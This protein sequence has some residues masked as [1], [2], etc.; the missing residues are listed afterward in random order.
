MA[1]SDPSSPI[2]I[3]TLDSTRPNF[4]GAEISS[5]FERFPADTANQVSWTAKEV[6]PAE[7]WV[8]FASGSIFLH[9]YTQ[10]TDPNRPYVRELRDDVS[11][12]GEEFIYQNGYQLS[13]GENSG[14]YHMLFP[15]WF[16][17]T[18]IKYISRGA[19]K[20]VFARVIDT[21]PVITWVFEDHLQLRITMKE[22]FQ[23]T[24]GAKRKFERDHLY[25]VATANLGEKTKD[26]EIVKEIK[27]N[28]VQK[29]FEFVPKVI[30]Y[31]A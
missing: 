7:G 26:S 6:D 8:A 23:D 16:V 13:R 29:T 9:F 27:K 21:R 17:P 20:M 19:V 11:K 15:Q 14:I 22:V 2:C 3:V 4:G 28:A 31:F 30:Q 18:E 10:P 5:K 25:E 1:S 12:V 24:W